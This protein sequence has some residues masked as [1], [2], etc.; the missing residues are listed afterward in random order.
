MVA[1]KNVD[2]EAIG[3]IAECQP[4]GSPIQLGTQGS[5][6]GK[7]FEVVGRIQLTYGE[8]FWNEWFLRYSDGSE[9]WL[10]EALGQFFINK[11]KTGH[12][13]LDDLSLGSLVGFDGETW[14]VLDR[15]TVG[16]SSFEGELPYLVSHKETF[17][18]V[19]LRNKDG[20][21]LTVDC[22][23]DKPTTYRGDWVPFDALSL[24]GLNRDEN[25]MIAVPSSEVRPIK[26]TSCG[27][28]HEITGPGRAEVF[29]CQYCDT[30]L[31]VRNP[32]LKTIDLAF[33]KVKQ[34][35]ERATIP[36]GASAKFPKAEYKVIGMV[37]NSTTVQGKTYR[38]NDFLLYN[39]L[40]GYLWVNENNGHYTLFEQL[41]TVPIKRYGMNPFKRVVGDPPNSFVIVD[42]DKYKHFSTANVRVTAVLGEFYWRVKYGEASRAQDYVNPPQM[43]SAST[44][45]SDITWTKGR[46]L[47]QSELKEVFPDIDFPEPVGVGTAQPSPYKAARKAFFP[48]KAAG[49]ILAFLMIVSGVFLPDGKVL[50]ENINVNPESGS[51]TTF[52]V[53]GSGTRSVR[54]DLQGD[55]KDQW[56]DGNVVLTPS[57]RSYKRQRKFM[58][59][60]LKGKGQDKVSVMVYSV[61]TNQPISISVTGKYGPPGPAPA[62]VSD[63]PAARSYSLPPLKATVTVMP[64]ARNFSALFYMWLL[65]LLPN[66]I[67]RRGQSSFETKRWYESDYG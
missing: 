14:V 29:V 32:E 5:Y 33:R 59:A 34:V 25:P 47:T 15:K 62:I 20:E 10:G 66:W 35:A 45:S 2:L 24:T 39:H 26:C 61:P 56:L 40:H 64:G 17:L 18:T 51:Q 49:Y 46:Y 4:D 55:L 67:L 42:G 63:D 12:P 3:K 1:R 19:D 41:Y 43:V 27:A 11:Q 30:A 65:L 37:E 48:I 36:V 60:S 28:P 16:V 9:G 8:G 31:D 52:E 44:T 57:K 13:E 54:V 50:A 21:G 6:K 22:S 53:P 38:W 23:D 58:L 7:A